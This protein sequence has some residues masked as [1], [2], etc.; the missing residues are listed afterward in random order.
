MAGPGQNRKCWGFHMMSAYPPTAP[1]ELDRYRHLVLRPSKR[2]KAHEGN[3]A[4]CRLVVGDLLDN[5][6]VL[7]RV[8]VPHWHHEP[9]THFKLLNRRRQRFTVRRCDDDHVKW[10]TFSA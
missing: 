3:G 10:S 5:R 4:R 8:S 6:E 7:R 9:A 2:H 1:Q